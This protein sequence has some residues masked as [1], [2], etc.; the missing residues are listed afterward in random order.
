M[1]FRLESKGDGG[2]ALVGPKVNLALDEGAAT[3]VAWALERDYFSSV[4]LARNFSQLGSEG[5]AAWLE[6]MQRSGLIEQM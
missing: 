1:H 4:L 5:L 2:Q 3:L 6:T